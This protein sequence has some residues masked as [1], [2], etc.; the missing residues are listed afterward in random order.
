[1]IFTFLFLLHFITWCTKV[2]FSFLIHLALRVTDFEKRD[3]YRLNISF[4]KCPCLKYYF[5]I[6]FNYYTVMIFTSFF[7]L[8]H[9]ITCCTNIPS[10]CPIHLA[11]WVTEHKLY[12]RGPDK[13]LFC[14]STVQYVCGA[15]SLFKYCWNKINEC[16]ATC[17]RTSGRRLSNQQGQC[18]RK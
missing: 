8:L 15:S 7:S 14:S 2:P 5:Y 17:V 6:Q 10:S 9:F 3:L 11:L 18:M 12:E 13:F 4:M 1:M 16:R